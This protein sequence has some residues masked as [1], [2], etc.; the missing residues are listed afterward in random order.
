MER[1]ADRHQLTV[2]DVSLECGSGVIELSP[3]GQ[4]ECPYT[5]VDGGQLVG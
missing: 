2:V 1:S 4:S 5:S 3:P